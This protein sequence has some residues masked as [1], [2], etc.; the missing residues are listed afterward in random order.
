MSQLIILQTRMLRFVS[1]VL[2]LCLKGTLKFHIIIQ[3]SYAQKKENET[4]LHRR[5]QKFVLIVPCTNMRDSRWHAFTQCNKL[6]CF[7]LCS[8]FEYMYM[9]IDILV[10][11]KT[12][13]YRRC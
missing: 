11:D 12:H 7:Y 6:C 2:E 1:L 4:D 9:R 10:D 3:M 5:F 8:N 13:F